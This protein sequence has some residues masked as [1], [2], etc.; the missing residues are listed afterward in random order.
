[1]YA[2]STTIQSSPGS[3]DD[4]IAYMRDEVWP[5]MQQMEGCVGLSMMCD[6]ESGRCIATSSW[7]DQASMRAS[8]ERVHPMRDHMIERFG[9]GEPEVHE[10]EVAVLHREHPTGDGACARITWVR[11]DPG[12]T[13]QMLDMYRS[14][15]MPR[16]QGMPG[17]CSLSMF[18]DR[19]SGRGV[20]SASFDSRAALEASREPARTIR[21]GVTA[22]GVDILDVAEMDLVLAHLRVPETV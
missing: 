10:W 19:E 16:I 9:G 14:T 18:V 11:T 7:Q 6:R 4:A 3:L 1:M 2:R 5:Q 8:A 20:G 12:R 17:F 22:Q 21:E 15:V 13:D